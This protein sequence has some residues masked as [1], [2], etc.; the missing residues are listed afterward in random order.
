MKDNW[1][2]ARRRRRGLSLM[3]VVLSTLL[4]GFVLVGA[5]QCAASVITGRVCSGDVARAQL[6][7]HDLLA[8]IVV[9]P[10]EDEGDTPVFGPETSESGLT[11]IFFDDVDDYDGWS[12]SPPQN[13][14]GSSYLKL[15]GWQRDVTVEWVQPSNPAVAVGTEQGLKRITVTVSRNGEAL[16]TA[17]AIRSDMYVAE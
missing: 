13:H 4:I 1:N 7:A 11:R 5:L 9:E 12:K 2:R 10:Y 15:D 6:L 17:I 8:E 16:A 3:E 14:D